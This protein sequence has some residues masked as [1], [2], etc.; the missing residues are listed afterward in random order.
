[1]VI[2]SDFFNKKKEDIFRDYHVVRES[3]L[4]TRKEKILI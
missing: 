2:K 3:R 1:M 4:I